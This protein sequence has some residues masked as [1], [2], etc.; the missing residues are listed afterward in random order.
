VATHALVY[1]S[2]VDMMPSGLW[3][4]HLIHYWVWILPAY[5]LLGLLV[6]RDLAAGHQPRERRIAAVSLLATLAVLCLHV[7][8]VAATGRRAAFLDFA[9][10]IPRFSDAYF[11]HWRIRDEMAEQT[12]VFAIRGQPVPGGLRVFG[13]ARDFVG[14]V[15]WASDDAFS[16]TYAGQPPTRWD[17]GLRFGLPCWTHLLDCKL[18]GSNAMFTAPLS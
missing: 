11:E 6:L 1:L 18:P 16:Q 14:P 13:M 7:V 12:N 8:P 15:T 2:Y 4:Y 5:G 9:G 10:P 3:R 17:F